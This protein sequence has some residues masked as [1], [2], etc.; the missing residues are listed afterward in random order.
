M[1]FDQNSI[2]LILCLATSW[3]VTFGV[4][5][6]VRNR[7]VTSIHA[8]NGSLEET[9]AASLSTVFRQSP[10]DL[11]NGLH[12]L[13]ASLAMRLIAPLAALALLMVSD[14]ASMLGSIGISSASAQRM[15]L[16]GIYL[17]FGYCWFMVLSQQRVVWGQGLIAT[18]GV[19][20]KRQ[21]RAMD[22]L[23]EIRPH[24]TRPALVLTF[25]DQKP[26]YIPKSLS[27]RDMFIDE[28][29]EIAHANVN[30]GMIVPMPLLR[31]RLGV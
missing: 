24:A 19:D 20:M 13:R 28:M 11:G 27:H 16:G 2:L 6:W 7:D 30:N 12:E 5:R 17:G 31:Q 23:L 26:L 8:K 22:D 29:Q 1:S 21:V 14:V 15:I 10:V 3:L 4:T 9:G 18:Y 25:S